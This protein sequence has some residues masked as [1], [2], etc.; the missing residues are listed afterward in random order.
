MT[1]PTPT[2]P[3][4][5]LT[6]DARAQAVNDIF[7]RIAGR[8]DLMNRIMTG[9]FDKGWRRFVIAKANIPVG[10]K[11]L[12]I[13]TGTGDLAFE[14]LEQVPSATAIGADFVPQMMIVGRKRPEGDRVRWNSADALN[15]PYADYTFDAVTHGFLVRNVIDIPRALSEQY[16]VLKPGGRV[17]CLDTTPPPNTPLRP[18]IVLYMT[19][20]IPLIGQV[21]TGAQDAY[22]YLPNSSLGFKT[23]DQ[24]A[25]LFRAA[26]FRDVS[27]RKFM[28]GTTAVHWG[29][30]PL[31]D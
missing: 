30:K 19:R 9:G 12:D 23:A 8:Y 27:Y 11:M 25:D 5:S 10:G 26:G 6:G 29:T 3:A 21:L 16:R 1:N 24:L 20:V 7:A 28:F 4:E 2:K 18:F 17:V 31:N 13:A 14:A 22:S 15:L